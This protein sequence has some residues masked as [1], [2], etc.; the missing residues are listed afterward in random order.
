MHDVP[1][2][3]SDQDARKL[4]R[5]TKDGYVLTYPALSRIPYNLMLITS[6]L[7]RKCYMG[8]KFLQTLQNCRYGRK[9]S[10]NGSKS[11]RSIRSSAVLH[12]V[13]HLQKLPVN[14]T[15]SGLK[16]VIVIFIL[17]LLGKLV[18]WTDTEAQI[19][20]YGRFSRYRWRFQQ[21]EC[22]IDEEGVVE[23]RSR[24]RNATVASGVRIHQILIIRLII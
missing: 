11:V 24:V 1:C 14:G 22:S 5:W 13:T 9:N 7:I 6:S 12:L 4:W 2:T 21:P 15:H 19:I 17:K 20:H 8:N 3:V 18:Q 10:R 23:L 16:E